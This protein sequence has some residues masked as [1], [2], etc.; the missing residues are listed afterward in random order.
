MP[1]IMD[2]TMDLNISLFM[3]VNWNNMTG[4]ILSKNLLNP[5]VPSMVPYLGLKAC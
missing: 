5:K 4:I 2:P 1:G 3:G